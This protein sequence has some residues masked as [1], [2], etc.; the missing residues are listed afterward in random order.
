MFHLWYYLCLKLCFFRL[1]ITKYVL[2]HYYKFSHRFLVASIINYKQNC[3]YS[4]YLG[5]GLSVSQTILICLRNSLFILNFFCHLLWLITNFCR[6]IV[7]KSSLCN[8]KLGCC[9]RGFEIPKGLVWDKICRSCAANTI[10]I[11][12]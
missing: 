11:R 9:R 3:Y 1:T 7:Q 4:F 6:I 8:R 2:L 5:S 10:L 12:S